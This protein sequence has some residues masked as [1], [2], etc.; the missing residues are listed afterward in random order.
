MTFLSDLWGIL[1]GDGV[2]LDEDEAAALGAPAGETISVWVAM[3]AR[4]GSALA[5]IACLALFLVQW[6]HCHDQLAGVPM[7][8]VNYLRALILLLLFAPVA[9]VVWVTRQIVW[10][11]RQMAKPAA[12]LLLVAVIGVLTSAFMVIGAAKSAAA[13]MF[14]FSR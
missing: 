1:K 9:A 14:F 13:L 6:R 10:G 8:P 3:D 7:Q 11:M 2:R 5:H 12:F 4:H